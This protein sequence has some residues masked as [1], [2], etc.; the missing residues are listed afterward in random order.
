M[1]EDAIKMTQEEEELEALRSTLGDDTK[2]NKQSRLAVPYDP[3]DIDKLIDVSTSSSSSNDDDFIARQL[4]D[5][6]A[7]NPHDILGDNSCL[8]VTTQ[9]SVMPDIPRE[10]SK[11][12]ATLVRRVRTGKTACGDIQGENESREWTVDED[13]TEEWLDKAV[14]TMRVGEVAVYYMQADDARCTQVIVDSSD[15][16]ASVGDLE[17]T[18]EKLDRIKWLRQNGNKWFAQRNYTRAKQRYKMSARAAEM[19]ADTKLEA[20]PA[21]ANIAACCLQSGGDLMEALEACNKALE[22]D[23]KNIK[24]WYRRGRVL[25]AKDAFA[26]A[27]DDLKRALEIDPKNAAVRQA[28]A[29]LKQKQEDMKKR[30]RKAFAGCFDKM[31][32]FASNKRRSDAGIETPVSDLQPSSSKL[33]VHV[34]ELKRCFMDIA[35]DSEPAG[36]IVFELFNDTV[37]NTVENFRCLCTGEKVLTYKNS[38]FHRVIKNFM[39]QGGDITRR[40]GTG[41]T[42]IFG[43]SFE[44]EK[45]IDIHNRP[46][47]LSMA[48]NGPNTNN[49][50]FFITTASS[51]PH[52]DG[53]HVVF[54]RVAQGMDVVLKIEDVSTV[55]PNDVP[56]VDC[57][58]IDCGELDPIFIPPTTP[59]ASDGPAPSSQPTDVEEKDSA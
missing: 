18:K 26:A 23:E 57:T 7:Q 44:D 10:L 59:A 54:G 46:G 16:P 40:D 58:V 38:K 22:L 25:I 52:L 28:F 43:D 2:V 56:A 3:S 33:A 45:F 8:K 6:T 12:R 55:G 5:A 42:S 48:N 30:A 39:I 51:C 15:G 20:S 11:V 21:H 27:R 9:K 35:I 53:K 1:G 37:P 31:A 29:D 41:G 34:G 13:E 50:Q 19:D 14:Q 4:Q 49:S 17:S 32:G 36:R 24:A 47:L